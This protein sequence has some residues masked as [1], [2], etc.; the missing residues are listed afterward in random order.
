MNTTRK[1]LRLLAWALRARCSAGLRR[2]AQRR[3]ARLLGRS[4][5]LRAEVNDR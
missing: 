4:K 5:A 2:A 1:P 3:L